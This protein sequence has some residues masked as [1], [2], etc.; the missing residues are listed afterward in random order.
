MILWHSRQEASGH[1]VGH[2]LRHRG[3][4]KNPTWLRQNWTGLRSEEGGEGGALSTSQGIKA[5]PWH[6]TTPPLPHTHMHWLCCSLSG[7]E[8]IHC[9]PHRH[10]QPQSLPCTRPAPTA[11]AHA[12][13][14][15]PAPLLTCPSPSGS[16]GC[17]TNAQCCWERMKGTDL[18]SKILEEL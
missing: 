8:T 14:P 18:H 5:L 11:S 15:F 16:H 17:L 7:S 4:G 9:T 6:H 2:F 12:H 3:Q 1:A 10:P 13:W